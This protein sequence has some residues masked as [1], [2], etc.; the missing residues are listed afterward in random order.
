MGVATT[1]KIPYRSFMAFPIGLTVLVILG[2]V[3]CQITPLEIIQKDPYPISSNLEIQIRRAAMNASSA[4]T[5]RLFSSAARLL[6]THNGT[7]QTKSIIARV[8]NDPALFSRLSRSDRFEVELID[9][10]LKYLSTNPRYKNDLIKQLEV[11]TPTTLVQEISAL[12]LAAQIRIS[13]V[14]HV[15]AVR[16]LV[17]LS[18]YPGVDEKQ[19]AERIWSSIKKIP[20]GYSATLARNADTEDEFAWWDLATKFLNPLTPTLQQR[21]WD[22]W[23]S[24]NPTHL[25]NKQPPSETSN[26][27]DEPR[28]IALLLPQ[29]GPLAE[30]S[31]AIRDGFVAAYWSTQL[32]DEFE[33]HRQ[34]KILVYDTFGNTMA[35]VVSRAQADGA[36]ILLGPL[37]KSNVQSMSTLKTAIP[38]IALNRVNPTLQPK[39]TEARG[40]NG[41]IPQL[42]LAVEDE[43]VELA[44]RISNEGST[45]II[46]F[47]DRTS[48]SNRAYAAFAASISNSVEIVSLT[49]FDDLKDV[50]NAVGRALDIDASLMRHTNVQ[51]L[52]RREIEF[53]PRRRS[54][55]HAV[56]GLVGS[57]EYASLVA[58]LDFHFGSDIPL[59]ATSAAV[60]SDV[61][62][63]KK[64]GTRFVALPL[65]L[66]SFRLRH[67]LEN[68]FP[69]AKQNPSF[70]ALGI[71]AYRLANQ[72]ERLMAGVSIPATTGNLKL[73]RN[74]L[75]QRV[76]AWG[77]ITNNSRI[78]RPLSI[79]D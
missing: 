49:T 30:A 69:V 28:T 9:L 39:R 72:F 36:Q 41:R 46:V 11:L 19:L 13:M 3:G 75:I 21:G 17:R 10:E 61:P 12:E 27:P 47:R 48:W 15:G 4:E 51:R 37:S 38:T 57:R 65:T 6:S 25:A 59:F 43:A 42:S 68:A 14:D 76:P 58:A 50:T 1:Y 5:A 60:R 26:R 52:V 20:L 34:Q 24:A 22:V 53:V 77:Q 74:N 64:N 78:A 8:K 2:V 54:D 70:Y 62:I 35:D 79:V 32:T 23:R 16:T 45:R 44:K 7:Q 63:K 18:T 31:R 29:N 56:V 55:I 71:D 73:S 67:D 66:F 40:P 33:A